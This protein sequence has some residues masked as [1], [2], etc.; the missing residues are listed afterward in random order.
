MNEPKLK[1]IKNYIDNPNT[2]FNQLLSTV[3]W[4][5]RMK[6]RKTA[7]YG[8]SYNYSGIS[9]PDRD[10]HS[11]L[12]PICDQL[13]LEL[14]YLPNNCLLNYYPDGESSMG[15]HSDS[16]EGIKEDTGVT[17]ISLGATR[18]IKYKQI[19]DKNQTFDYPLDSGTLLY[20][21]NDVQKTWLHAI[22]KQT[23]IGPRIS[24]TFRSIL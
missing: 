1:I 22:P 21:D 8:A 23:G 11:L 17:I 5:D 24:L 16:S 20:M 4:D 19:E 12:K 9:Y 6:S 13:K 15:F 7:S 10:M 3:E 2:L 14:S 18:I